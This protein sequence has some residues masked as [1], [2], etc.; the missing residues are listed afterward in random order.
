MRL[1]ALHIILAIVVMA[2]TAFAQQNER[3]ITPVKPSTNTVLRP[4]KGTKEEVVQRYL[5]GDTASAAAELRRDSLSRVYPRYPLLTQAIFG[6]NFGDALLMAFGQK[7]GSFGVSTT[8]NMWNRLQP[9]VELG[10]GFANNTPDDMNF[11]YKGKLAPY[12]KLGANYNFTFKHDPRYQV[13]AGLR[14]GFSAF[15]YDV[16]DV[17]Y[18][19]H[20]WQESDE[21][22]I[23]GQSGHALWGEFL[24]GLRVNLWKN[25]DLGWQARYRGV[26]TEKKNAQSRAWFI[27]GYGDRDKSFGFTMSVYYTLP[28]TLHKWP[29]KEEPKTKKK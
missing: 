24:M 7:Y 18:Q 28:L 19:D 11:T 12:F 29:K 8:L 10:V 1:K 20:Y 9:E 25:L 22:S 26:F 27:P 21:F 2:S 16:T 3:R 4:A 17:H 15:K 6:V 5:E 23:T 13:Y 14:I